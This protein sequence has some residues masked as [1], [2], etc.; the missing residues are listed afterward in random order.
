MPFVSFKYLCCLILIGLWSQ[1]SSAKLFKNS[2]VSFELPAK[3]NCQLTKTTWNCSNQFE[4]KNKS[5]VIVLA[6]KEAGPQDTLTF[7]SKKISQKPGVYLKNK[8]FLKSKK[9]QLKNTNINNHTW[10]D[11]LSYNSEAPNY[12]TRYLA[13]V[14][15]NI[16]ILITFTSHKDQYTLYVN[17]F[18]RA[19]SSLKVVTNKDTLGTRTT[20][21]SVTGYKNSPN[22]LIL[23]E[24]EPDYQ[25]RESEQ[26]LFSKQNMGVI[27]ILLI[28]ALI[29]I[30][31]S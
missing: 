16:G 30:I 28:G 27:L 25:A 1:A 31:R 26:G 9:I 8:K 14:K 3:W 19:I 17:E 21:P 4:K 24:E 5:A 7:Y 20:T 15:N 12:Y 11:G 2:F 22:H 6:A 29:Y 23:T 18:L 13:T 10:V